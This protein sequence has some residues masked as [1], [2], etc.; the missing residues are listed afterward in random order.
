MRLILAAVTPTPEDTHPT[1]PDW[2]RIAPISRESS[3]LGG[4]S[5][6]QA[7]LTD[8]HLATLL[9][10]P[11]RV[12]A[13]L[14]SF[15]FTYQ[16]VSR[17]ATNDAKTVTDAALVR[18]ARACPNLTTFMLQGTSGLGDESFLA[19]YEH[20]PNL[21]F[22]ELTAAS[23]DHNRFS[24]RA[25]EALSGNP[26]WMPRLKKLLLTINMCA[27]GPF[28]NAMKAM[29]KERPALLITSVTVDE[30]KKWGDWEM[31]KY[32]ESWKKGRTFV[33]RLTYEEYQEVFG[34]SRL[35]MGGFHD[36]D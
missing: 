34:R 28:M 5:N 35:M 1:V 8:P 3:G 21:T 32:E 16:D 15:E 22:L 2:L 4:K 26:G 9:Q 17:D 6:S 19:F 25:F 36:F 31:E 14:K 29:S 24:S 30:R 20:C 7:L 11:S 12:C 23:G 13:A 18:L 10:L 27:K 33:P